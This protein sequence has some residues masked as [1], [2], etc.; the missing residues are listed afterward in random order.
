M[1]SVWVSLLLLL[2]VTSFSLYGVFAMEKSIS[3]M[4]ASLSRLENISVKEAKGEISVLEAVFEK[5]HTLLAISLPMEDVDAVRGA[6]ILL[7]DAYRSENE[8][9]FLDACSAL[10]FALYRLRDAAVPSF[11]TIF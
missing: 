1:R 7:K 10:S 2:V 11:E 5:R 4:E 6:L 9:A 3:Q 8:D